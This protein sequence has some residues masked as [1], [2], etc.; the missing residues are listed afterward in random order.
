M[1]HNYCKKFWT[2]DFCQIQ[3]EDDR[4]FSVETSSLSISERR[5]TL[6]TLTFD[7]QKN[8]HSSF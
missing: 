8:Q 3:I 1:S 2:A 6:M 7:V 5:L 4:I